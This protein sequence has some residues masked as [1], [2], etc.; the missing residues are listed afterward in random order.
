[1]MLDRG[2]KSKT[3]LGRVLDSLGKKICSFFVTE[4][5]KGYLVPFKIKPLVIDEKINFN[6]EASRVKSDSNK[7]IC[8]IKRQNNSMKMN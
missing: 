7:L 5:Q 6:L 2:R 4:E 1:M 8:E 3:L